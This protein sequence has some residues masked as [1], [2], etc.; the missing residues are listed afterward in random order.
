MT[1]SAVLHADSSSGTDR[2]SNWVLCVPLDAP[3]TLS[4]DAGRLAR[5][6]NTRA[7]FQGRLLN[8]SDIARDLALADAGVDDAT[9][10]AMAYEKWGADFVQRLRG[11]YALATADTT[12]GLT[13]IARDHV[14]IHSLFYT[15]TRELLLV[16]P[17]P[18]ALIERTGV[19]RALNRAAIADRLCRRYVDIGETYF[20]AV[21][22]LP[23][24]HALVVGARGLELRRYWNP[25]PDHRGLGRAT[26]D[27][28][29]AF[30]GHIE[31]AVRR[32]AADDGL[33]VFVS[34]GLDSA[35]V[36]VEATRQR[37][38]RHQTPPLALSLGIP[39]PAS[40]ERAVQAA[41]A[42]ELGI[43]SLLID[44]DQA[45]P[46][47][48]LA[49]AWLEISRWMPA[50]L[51]NRWLPA[52]LTLVARGY[53]RGVRTVLTGEGGDEWLSASPYELAEFLRRGRVGAAVSFNQQF[54][55]SVPAR[56]L[57][58]RYGLRPLLA[59]AASHVVGTAWTRRRAKRLADAD[60]EWIAPDG[61]VRAAQYQRAAGALGQ[62]SPAGGFVAAELRLHLDHPV[63]AFDREEAFAWS[64][65]AS[66]TTLHPLMDADL[67]GWAAA[68]PAAVLN[69]GGWL[70]GLQR[71][72]LARSLPKTAIGEQRKVLGGN[73]FEGI[74]EAQL[75][76]LPK[77]VLAL[78]A[79]AQLG[80]VDAGHATLRSIR[81]CN[82][83][84]GLSADRLWDLLSMEMWVQAQQF[85]LN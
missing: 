40:D 5:H 81:S 43:D 1:R 41:I 71:Q 11:A 54:G 82:L 18:Q 39:H 65:R 73:F 38:V 51:F 79:L 77:S 36:C 58:W 24:G 47:N 57:M 29:G 16:S 60:P 49:D 84:A 9:L 62:A 80:V 10:T 45:T 25:V 42:H 85:T 19:S 2:L 23:S 31:T 30:D 35:T 69:H 68:M 33:G 52:Y 72:R 32:C 15:A 78:D 74:L 21:R 7:W 20:E 64:Q 59:Q 55:R 66:V 63:T 37:L 17:S 48:G 28:V 27:A 61:T 56:G 76:K 53:A 67:I 26:S 83:P 14:G 75:T 6:H 44:F 13:I 50:P 22:R 34:G 3:G 70:K 12:R 4:V 8:R 46:R